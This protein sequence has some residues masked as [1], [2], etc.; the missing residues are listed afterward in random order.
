MDEWSEK[1]KEI[2][3]QPNRTVKRLCHCCEEKLEVRALKR[4][5]DEWQKERQSESNKRQRVIETYINQIAIDN[6]CACRPA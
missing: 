4:H 6:V 5:R 2:I 3:E 1:W